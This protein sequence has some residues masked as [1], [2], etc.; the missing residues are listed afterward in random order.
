MTE[1]PMNDDICRF[2]DCA[3]RA[4][5]DEQSIDRVTRRHRERRSQTIGQ[6]DREIYFVECT[7]GGCVILVRSVRKAH[8]QEKLAYLGGQLG[9]EAVPRRAGPTGK[10]NRVKLRPIDRIRIDSYYKPDADIA[11]L[12]RCELREFKPLTDE[13]PSVAVLRRRLHVFQVRTR[14]QARASHP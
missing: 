12:S 10:L 4:V 3:A 1:T 7:Y 11:V 6:V 5:Y 2:V 13:A 9:A 14:R 8:E